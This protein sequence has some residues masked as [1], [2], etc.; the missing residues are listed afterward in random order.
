MVSHEFIYMYLSCEGWT[1]NGVPNQMLKELL[2]AIYG[3]ENLNVV[4]KHNHSALKNT[5][6]SIN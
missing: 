5:I 4:A 2:H 3:I 1:Q 6:E